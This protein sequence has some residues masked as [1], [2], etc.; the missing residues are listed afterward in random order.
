MSVKLPGLIDKMKQFTARRMEKPV[1]TFSQAKI[2][3]E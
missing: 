3:S 1:F 2:H